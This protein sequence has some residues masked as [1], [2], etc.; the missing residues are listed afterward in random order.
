MA[1]HMTWESIRES[2]AFQG[3]WVALDGCRYDR[4]HRPLEAVVVDADQNLSALF[5]R[6]HRS[7]HAHCDI[8][9]CD[10]PAPPRSSRMARPVRGA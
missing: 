8:L 6:L 4:A 9:F 7:D 5:E 3:C 1:K 2:Q 10:E